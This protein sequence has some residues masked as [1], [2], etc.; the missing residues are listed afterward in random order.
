MDRCSHLTSVGRPAPSAPVNGA[1]CEPRPEPPADGWNEIGDLDLETN[2]AH[3][4]LSRREGHSYITL[5]EVE[6]WGERLE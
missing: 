4:R 5:S 6:I 1:G 3:M 2:T